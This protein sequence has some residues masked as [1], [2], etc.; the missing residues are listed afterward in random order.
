MA[1][2]IKT[3]KD[4]ED[5][6]LLKSSLEEIVEHL[7]G[8]PGEDLAEYLIDNLQYDLLKLPSNPS[9]DLKNSIIDLMFQISLTS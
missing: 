9:P 6:P 4:L 8:L 3:S 1:Q 7:E 5:Y 2:F